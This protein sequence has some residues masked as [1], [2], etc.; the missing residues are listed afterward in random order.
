MTTEELLR[1]LLAKEKKAKASVRLLE[2]TI[3]VVGARYS[4][5]QGY[6]TPLTRSTLEQELNK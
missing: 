3:K 5:E 1:A 2:A 4:K 6:L